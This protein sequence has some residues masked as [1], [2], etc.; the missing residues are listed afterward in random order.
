MKK[1]LMAVVIVVAGCMWS[2]AYDNALALPDPTEQLRPFVA[3]IIQVL[4]GP[5]DDGAA[6]SKVDRIMAV[7]QEGFDFREMSKR[8]LGRHWKEI[9]PEEQE[10]FVELFTE[11]LKY[12][13]VSQMENYTNQ[14][15]EYGKQ[16]IRGKRAQVQTVLVD[17]E[18]KIPVSYIMLLRGEQWKVYDVVVEGV[19]LIRNYL[20]QFQEILRK[21]DFKNLTQQLKN[22]IVEFQKSETVG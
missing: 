15:V 1:R 9:S 3:Q 12:A 4:S 10:Q 2:G 21:D 14:K 7:A 18:R 17:G 20:E 5:G 22:K 13:Y 6:E 8:V 19:S 16:R 11:L